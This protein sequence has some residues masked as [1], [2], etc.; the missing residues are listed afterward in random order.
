MN[1]TD[2]F[3]RRPVLAAVVSLV[4]L[5]VSGGFALALRR[6]LMT[7]SP[8]PEAVARYYRPGVN[9]AGRTLFLVPVFGVALLAM[10]GGEWSVSDA[11]VSLGSAGWALVAMVAEGLLW[12]MER[13]L[14]GVVVT[15]TGGPAAHAADPTDSGVVADPPAL[16]LR[17]GLLGMGLGAVLVAVA[18]VMAA[19]P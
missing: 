16:C 13:R 9:W 2:I 3:I 7:D 11:W 5:L 12:P 17:A 4:A 18:V 8:V 19:K 10:S 14:Q 15:R 6:A 1:F